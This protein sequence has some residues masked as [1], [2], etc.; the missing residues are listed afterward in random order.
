MRRF[1]YLLNLA[2]KSAWNRKSTL[3]LVVF[4]IALSTTLLIGIERV[5]SQL[6][7]S[8]VQAIS[9]T[10]L[11]VGA[12]GNGVQLI[13][14]AVFHIGS[15]TNNMSWDSA[16]RIASRDDVAWTIPLS[17]GDS[18]RGFPV[19]GTTQDY[20]TH[21][22]Y[23]RN[24]EL[25]FDRGA[26]FVDIFDV[27]L[28]AGVARQTGYVLGDRIT[29]THGTGKSTSSEH[30]DMPFAIT[31]I[32]AP[33]GTPVDTSLYI[34]LEGFEAIHL[35]WQG[36]APMPGFRIQAEHVT[37]FNLAPKN[38]TALFV[39]LKNR[40]RVF[41]VQRDINTDTAEALTGVMPGVALDQ[42]WD[43]LN[44]GE[45]ALLFISG[46]VTVAGLAGLASTII[47]GLG[48]RRR[49]L[50]ILRSAGAS[51][52]DV[53][54]LLALEGMLLMLTGVLIGMAVLCAIIVC[55]G[56]ILAQSYGIG[57]D[58]S[59]LTSGEWALLGGIV[60]AGFLTSL[61]PALR[62]YRMSLMDG[63]SVST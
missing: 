52:R 58:L 62:A 32:L 51:P 21:Y 59:P 54:T 53:V 14:Y 34:S 43:M 47:A 4:A 38:I 26:P 10:D 55:L 50:A 23:Q 15:A 1:C 57:L 28:G 41:A 25:R 27:V 60:A 36:G 24:R 13:L 18:H 5:R 8:F 46:L 19:V 48:E 9:G 22:R 3:A 30:A 63:L 17:L 39:G 31:G 40:A 29:L 6:R 61:I 42:L 11:V 2:G 56:P 12:R 20:F 37:K 35:G 16:Q 7:Q 45:T 44:T 33:T 49:E